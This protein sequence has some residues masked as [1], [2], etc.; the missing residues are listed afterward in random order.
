MTANENSQDSLGLTTDATYCLP[1]HLLQL[2]ISCSHPDPSVSSAYTGLSGPCVCSAKTNNV[3]SIHLSLIFLYIEHGFKTESSWSL[4][5]KLLEA[6]RWCLVL[7]AFM[8]WL[9]YQTVRLKDIFFKDV[10]TEIKVSNIART[11]W[12]SPIIFSLYFFL[13]LLFALLTSPLHCVSNTLVCTVDISHVS[14]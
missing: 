8:W 11:P 7:L 5:E 2:N 4:Q 6:D 1:L 14:T 9:W 13:F 12:R 3:W 10:T